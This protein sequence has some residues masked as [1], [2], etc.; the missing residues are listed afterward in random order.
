MGDHLT[1]CTYKITISNQRVTNEDYQ[2]NLHTTMFVMIKIRKLKVYCFTSKLTKTTQKHTKTTLLW[3]FVSKL[4]KTTQKTRKKQKDA[5]H[6]ILT[7]R[8]GWEVAG[9]LPGSCREVAGKWPGGFQNYLKSFK[10]HFFYNF[11]QFWM[12]LCNFS[13]FF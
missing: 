9:K 7:P 3:R 8:S 2:I 6:Q 11:V 5:K 12:K 10:M 13:Y 1:V 4:T